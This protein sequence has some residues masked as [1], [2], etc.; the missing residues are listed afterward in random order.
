MS[1]KL[2]Q[3]EIEKGIQK[4][5]RVS[6]EGFPNG[7]Y[8]SEIHANIPEDAVKITYDQWQEFLNNHGRRKWVNG[9]V[10]NYIPPPKPFS[11]ET[12][13]AKINSITYNI[14]IDKVPE[15][16]Q[17]NM[18]ARSLFIENL[19][20]KGEST[21][22]LD[23][24]ALIIQNIWNDVEL[25][26]AKSNELCVEY[27]ERNKTITKEDVEIITAQLKAADN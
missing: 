11:P 19:Q 6:E 3:L 24:Q 2:T 20:R 16:K 25:I 23:E 14:I 22:V 10:V 5:M 18:L 12:T 7:F 9:E 4:Y 27:V 1:N 13:I 8:S 17:R 15:W 26:R 21:P